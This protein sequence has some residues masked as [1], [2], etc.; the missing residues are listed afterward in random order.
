MHMCECTHALSVC[1]SVS[2]SQHT[3]THTHLQCFFFPLFQKNIFGIGIMQK[4]E[5]K[6]VQ[7]WSLNFLVSVLAAR[8]VLCVC[9]CLSFMEDQYSP[10]PLTDDVYS[11]VVIQNVTTS[12]SLHFLRLLSYLK[13]YLSLILTD[14]TS[15]KQF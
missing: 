11:T 14:N 9:E 8:T 15:S 3:H 6:K 10:Y 1:L 12:L 7:V 13:E 2:L 5:E 4:W